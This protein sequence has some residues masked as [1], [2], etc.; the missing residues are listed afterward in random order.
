MKTKH[1]AY[2][3]RRNSDELY[4]SGGRWP[5]F[6]KKGKAWNS[7]SALNAHLNLFKD[8]DIQRYYGDC[9]IIEYE[10]VTTVASTNV[11]PVNVFNNTRIANKVSK[12]LQQIEIEENRQKTERYNTYLKLKREFDN[13][14]PTRGTE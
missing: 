11:T 5:S 6:S 13:E 1:C 12:A 10:L 4:S 14:E 7:R 2:R 3:I 9:D 8:A